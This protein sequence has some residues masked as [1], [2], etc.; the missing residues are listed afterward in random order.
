[1]FVHSIRCQIQSC[2]LLRYT[3]TV[4]ENVMRLKWNN[5]RLWMK[6]MFLLSHGN[7]HEIF[8]WKFN[9]LLSMFK[10]IFSCLLFRCRDQRRDYKIGNA[11]RLRK[12]KKLFRAEILMW[13]V[14]KYLLRISSFFFFQLLYLCVYLDTL[15]L[16]H[17]AKN[18]K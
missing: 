8:S 14:W 17:I 10:G 15:N 7:K 16:A 4:K 2:R 13:K 18:A 9:L 11:C 12:I 3:S 1:M 5:F 6:M